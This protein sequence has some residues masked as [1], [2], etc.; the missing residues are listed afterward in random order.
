MNEAAT[1]S[2]PSTLAT[3][4][5]E[6]VHAVQTS[7]H[8]AD[9]STGQ[10]NAHLNAPSSESTAWSQTLQS[11]LSFLEQADNGVLL[12]ILGALAILT[13][14]I[15]GRLGLLLIGLVA[16]FV[17]HDYC[18]GL[19][20]D[21]D[22]AAGNVDGRNGGIAVFSSRKRRELGIEVAARLL[23]WKP[24]QSVQDTNQAEN[25]SENVS[26]D[27]NSL[28]LS[29]I[30]PATADALTHLIDAI[31]DNYVLLVHTSILLAL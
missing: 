8:D 18:G 3:S 22:V 7:E 4:P 27:T 26:Q 5:L 28:D 31:I 14:L 11:I 13:Y 24:T 19:V 20:A 23:E 1:A 30:P 25:V 15:L 21:T 6:T 12:K 9:T 29:R 16:G 10:N 17:I 2:A